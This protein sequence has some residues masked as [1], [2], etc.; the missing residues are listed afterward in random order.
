GRGDPGREPGSRPLYP[1]ARA[2]PADPEDGQELRGA[3]VR[4]PGRE[5]L[6]DPAVDGAVDAG[7]DVEGDVP[8]GGAGAAAADEP[9][10]ALGH[11]GDLRLP[12]LL[13][14][15]ARLRRRQAAGE[16]VLQRF[17]LVAGRFEDRVPGASPGQD[18]GLGRR[19]GDRARAASER[20]ARHGD[21]G[22]ELAGAGNAAVADAAVDTGGD[23]DHAAGPVGPGSG[24]GAEPGAVVADR[25]AYAAAADAVADASVPAGRRA[26]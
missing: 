12:V 9:A 19:G 25:A 11:M 7:A 14:R 16:V 4:R 10:V 1:S 22:D 3:V 5:A 18:R 2:D 24:A 20:C 26:R 17:H 13:A 8:A 6:P 15:E 23:G 21:A